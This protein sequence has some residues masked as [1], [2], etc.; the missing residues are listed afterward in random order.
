MKLF[1]G[2]AIQCDQL[3]FSKSCFFWIA[4]QSDKLAGGSLQVA[5]LPSL[6]HLSYYS[7]LILSDSALRA[8]YIYRVYILVRAGFRRRGSLWPCALT[9]L[10]IGI[11]RG[12]RPN[13]MLMGLAFAMLLRLV[14]LA[15]AELLSTGWS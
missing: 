15:E 10:M 2:S 9:G 8:S 6:I 5:S 13:P 11:R 1:H 14:S 12:V 7:N 4:G 3:G